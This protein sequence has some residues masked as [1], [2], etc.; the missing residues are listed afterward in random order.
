MG[1]IS[2][3]RIQWN[4]RIKPEGSFRPNLDA[5]S[6]H[7]RFDARLGRTIPYDYI[8]PFKGSKGGL[9]IGTHI[10]LE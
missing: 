4:L 7:P 6:E 1:Y 8:N 5:R 2:K 3:W 9:E 10:P